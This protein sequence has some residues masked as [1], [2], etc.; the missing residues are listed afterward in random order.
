MLFTFVGG[1]GHFEP[2]RPLARAAA[3]AGHTVAVA[4]PPA[5]AP[6]VRDAGLAAIAGDGPAGPA[7]VRTALRPVDP[8]RE[9]RELRE[10]FVERAAPARAAQLRAVCE[11]FAPDALVC[12][13]TDFGAPVA[14]ERQGLPFALVRVTASGAFIRPDGVAGALD[15]VRAAHG[16]QPDPA[17]EARSRHLVLAPFP[18]ALRDPGASPP[19][20]ERAFRPWTPQPRSGAPPWPLTRPGAATAYFT[21]GTVFNLESGDLLERVLDALGALPIQLVATVGRAIDPAS[22]GPRPAHVHVA[23]VL[24]QAD[25][26]PWCDLVVSHGGSG[27]VLGALAH[28][29]PSL[30]LPLGAD[31]P[32]NAARCAA[33]G[34]AEVQDAGA[35]NPESLRA[36]A[37]RLL[38]DPEPRR[39]AGTL[40]EAIAALPGPAQAVAWIEELGAGRGASSRG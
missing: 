31:Q 1:E 10:R 25:V 32:L 35:L 15:A 24:P 38:E 34:V 33:L 26:L 6:L 21:L 2:L 20:T 28:G 40:R 5:M 36:A 19:P 11:D 13:E 4:C 14:A 29:L 30:L 39:R 8:A 37:T 23:R 3:E 7:P 27:S 22:L 17:L 9:E 12:D 16:L 18:P